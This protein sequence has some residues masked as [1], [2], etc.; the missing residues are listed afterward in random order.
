MNSFDWVAI[1]TAVILCPLALIATIR[2]QRKAEREIAEENKPIYADPLTVDENGY[3]W[4]G[5]A[6][7]DDE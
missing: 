5:P 6:P 3:V 4:Y 1:I 2:A 7:R